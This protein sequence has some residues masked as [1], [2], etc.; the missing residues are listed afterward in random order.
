MP[1]SPTIAIRSA[2]TFDLSCSSQLVVANQ[3]AHASRPNSIVA[4]NRMPRS[5]VGTMT[6]MISASSA[7]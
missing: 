7:S 6:K 5:L 4:E 1:G 3:N 2:H